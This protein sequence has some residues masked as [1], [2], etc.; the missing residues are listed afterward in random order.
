MPFDISANKDQAGLGQALAGV[1]DRM[2]EI[3][4]YCDSEGRLVFTNAAFRSWLERRGL[5]AH[6][7]GGAAGGTAGGIVQSGGAMDRLGES[8]RR[9]IGGERVVRVVWEGLSGEL[10]ASGEGGVIGVFSPTG[11]S[12]ASQSD[13]ERRLIAL[14]V[15]FDAVWDW[16]LK[17]GK[18]SW[19]SGMTHLFGYVVSTLTEELDFWGVRL[20]A[21][22]HNRV[23]SS[24]M[25][26][27]EGRGGEVWREEYRFL[28]ADGSYAWVVDRARVIRG[29]D[30]KPVRMIGAIRD[31]SEARQSLAELKASEARYRALVEATTL[32]VWRVDAA[33]AFIEPSLQVCKLV[34]VDPAKVHEVDWRDLIHPEDVKELIPKWGHCLA[35]G[36][37]Y[38]GE[39]RLRLVDGSYRWHSV[40]SAAVRDAEGRIVEWVGSNQDIHARKLVEEELQRSEER[41][42]ALA[43]A[44]STGVWRMDAAG[45]LVES[46]QAVRERLGIEIGSP[47]S[48]QWKLSIHPDDVDRLWGLWQQALKTGELRDCEQ[49]LLMADGSYRWHLLRAVAVRDEVGEIREW[50]GSNQDIHARKLAEEELQRSEERYRALAEASSTGVWRMDAEGNFTEPS[51]KGRESMGIEPGSLRSK[52]W[53]LSIHPDDLQ[54]VEALWSVALATGGLHECEQRLLMADGSYRWHLVRAVPV[55]DEAGKVREWVGSHQDIHQRKLAE[56]ELRRSEMRYRA[57]SEA[58]DAAVWTARPDGTTKEPQLKFAKITGLPLEKTEGWGWLEAVHPEDR[59]RTLEASR[60]VR[61][62]HLSA[63]WLYD[64]EHRVR[65]ADGQYRWMNARAAVVRDESGTVVEIVGATRDIDDRKKAEDQLQRALRLLQLIIQSTASAV[66]VTNERGEMVERSE[67]MESLTGLTFDQYRG[68]RW[69]SAYHPDE[70]GRIQDW[71][72]TA[73]EREEPAEWEH[74]LRMRDGSYRWFLGR[75]VP[76]R[77]L[78]GKLNGWGGAHVDIHVLKTVESELRGASEA[79]DRFLAVLSHE[80]RTPLTPVL[81]SAQILE[82]DETLPVEA[83]EAISVMRRNVELEIRLI[84]DLLDLTRITRNKLRMEPKPVDLARLMTNVLGI[85]N[86]D[87]RAKRLNLAVNLPE[88][89]VLVTGDAA[90]LHQVF[91]NLVKNSI[92]FTSEGGHIA[93]TVSVEDASA[94]VRIVDDGIGIPAAL[95]PRVFDAFMQGDH[96]PRHYGGLG[97]GLAIAKALVEL[98]GGTLEARSGGSG[99]GAEFAARFPVEHA[100]ATVPVAVSPGETASVK[101][102]RILLV[103]D[104]ADTAR[105]LVRLLKRFGHEPTVV[106]TVAG[107]LGALRSQKFDLLISDIGLPDGSGYDLMRQSAGMRPP[108]IAL[109]G[110]GMEDDMSRSKEVGFVDHLTKPVDAGLLERTILLVGGTSR[111]V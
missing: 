57:L 46:S 102:M 18:L 103:E 76:L 11:L 97:L 80:L 22:D 96:D 30:G 51:L 35:T 70:I 58:T 32:G 39:Q 56:E 37:L 48:R 64:V 47:R 108:A 77:D 79:K 92:K 10:S 109:S 59:E 100:G 94:V 98:H 14:E 7:A 5:A 45:R 90:R 60:A 111:K 105:V 25:E 55:R 21:E 63:D 83:R 49:R 43:E 24:L 15:T 19:N 74:R 50:V 85:C 78:D 33:G 61:E 13:L 82:A 95:L 75:V 73:A 72:A 2:A 71:F 110:F 34:G 93:V 69:M 81:T 67:S 12:G 40:R 6:E 28:R 23:M 107:G 4:F 17:T 104:H 3:A 52:D 1:L 16:D 31:E 99:R 41:Y 27:A 88:S 106:S 36:T 20:H 62:G 89:A 86:P 65:M 68:M 38:E 87:I 42:R 26:A 29:D 53:R 8:V 9:V 44:S 54:Q 91:W 84:D 66:C 101:C